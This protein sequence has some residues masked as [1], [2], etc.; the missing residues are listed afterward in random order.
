[1][2][3]NIYTIVLLAVVVAVI[4]SVV[5]ANITGNVIKVKG[6]K[7][8]TQ[9]YT[10]EEVDKLFLKSSN[11]SKNFYNREEIDRLILNIGA[12]SC[13][14]DNLCEVNNEISTP[15]GSTSD[16]ILTSDGGEILLYSG[17]TRVGKVLIVNNKIRVESFSLGSQNSS[18]NLSLDNRYVCT[19]R[20]GE[21]FQSHK[22]CHEVIAKY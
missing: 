3:Y 15:K 21:L 5:T 1:M 17:N 6:L 16:L 2:K 4:A 13:D 9:V 19:N 11:V 10:K 22:P 20:A 8:G 12:V 18:S 14:G 7:I